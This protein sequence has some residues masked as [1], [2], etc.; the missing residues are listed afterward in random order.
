MDSNLIISD[1]WATVGITYG[2][3]KELPHYSSTSIGK[4]PAKSRIKLISFIKDYWEFD[5]NGSKG[6]I[7][8]YWLEK[9]SVKESI[10]ADYKRKIISKQENRKRQDSRGSLAVPPEFRKETPLRS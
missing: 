3:V 4:V 1:L 10:I 9:D 5:F 8:N 6:Y 7:K 2:V